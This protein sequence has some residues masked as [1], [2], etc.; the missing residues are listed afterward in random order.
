MKSFIKNSY[1]ILIITTIL[2]TNFFSFSHAKS[3]DLKYSKKNI[4]NYFS[5]TVSLNQN[6]PIKSFNYFNKIQ[7]LKRIHSNYNNQFIRSLVLVEKFDEAF[8]FSKKIWKENNLYFE[9]DLLLGLRHYLEGDYNNAEKY[10]SRLN[11]VSEQNPFFKDFFGNIL[12]SWLKASENDKKTSYE[13]YNKIPSRYENLKQ[14]QNAFLHCYFNEE[15]TETVFNK[16]I[17]NKDNGFS[18]YYFFLTNYLISK[19]RYVDKKKLSNTKN[20]LY[21]SNILIKEMQ[22]FIIN[23]KKSKILDFFNCK[24][25]KDSMAEIFYIIANMYAT[26]NDYQMSNFYLKISLFL[27]NKFTPNK[28]LLAENY[29]YQKKYKPSEKIYNSIK[30]I[31]PIF[32]WYASKNITSI[33]L[34]TSDK[35]T[36]IE[37]LEKRFNLIPDPNVYHYYDM[38][39]YYKNNEYYKKSI[40]YYTLALKKI[41]KQ[42]DLYT[43]ILDRRGTTYENIGEWKNA[44]KDL[45]ECLKILPN[46]P[47]VLNYLAYTWIDKN[48]NINKALD[49][50]K[51]ANDLEPNNGY[52][53]DSL[54]WAYYLRKNYNESEKYLQKAVQLNPLDPIINDHYA[55]SLWMVKKKIQ[56]KYFWKYALGLDNVKQ[57]TKI[58]I[59]KKLVFGINNGL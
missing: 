28:I 44:E 42:H 4:F 1:L 18:R 37:Y 11:Q 8:K 19:N 21:N 5:G 34:I 22:N 35:E 36:S 48:T 6:N 10:F 17:R 40:K 31:G 49:M 50:L 23:N 15:E 3:I 46:Q 24:E 26:E 30:N 20:N 13:F 55:D 43:K 39:N 59:N 38:G 54:G 32:S 57:K 12:I 47:Y 41:D 58:G 16:V 53:I 52:I 2:L 27:N 45:L 56:A 7:N 51:L 14:I 29:L 33:S 25:P 9:A